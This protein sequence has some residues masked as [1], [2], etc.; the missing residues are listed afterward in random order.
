MSEK[1]EN[2]KQENASKKKDVVRKRPQRS[3]IV[4]G[5]IRLEIPIPDD[6]HDTEKVDYAKT[7]AKQIIEKLNRGK[8]RVSISV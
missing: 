1:T 5:T 6:K 2:T 3:V 7:R 4:T 8:V